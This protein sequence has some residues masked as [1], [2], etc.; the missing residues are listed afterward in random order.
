MTA[1]ITGAKISP[2]KCIVDLVFVFFCNVEYEW[3][4]ASVLVGAVLAPCDCSSNG[5]YHAGACFA[6]FYG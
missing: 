5:N 3:P 1:A 4:E 6:D 2:L